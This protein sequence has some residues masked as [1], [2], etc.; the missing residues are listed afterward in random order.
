[1]DTHR[2]LAH[3][4]TFLLRGMKELY[5][6]VLEE[7]GLPFELSASFVLG[8]LDLLGPIRLTRLAQELGLDPSSVSRQVS[9]LERNGLVA[10]EKDDSDLRAA[11]LV[12][13]A[14][15]KAAVDTLRT[16]RARELA[17]LMPGWSAEELADL[18]AALGRLNHDLAVRR[19]RTAAPAELA[20]RA[21]RERTA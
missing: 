1:M 21:R 4:L 6:R 7:S 9:S 16:A 15:G 3:E 17:R 12:L 19:E 5:A 18:N 8:N 14:K 2:Q 13:T 20:Q 11:R 10:K